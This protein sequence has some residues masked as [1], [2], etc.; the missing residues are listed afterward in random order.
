MFYTNV[1]ATINHNGVRGL[2]S[3][4]Q[5]FISIHQYCGLTTNCIHTTKWQSGL[6]QTHTHYRSNQM[7]FISIF[8][9]S[10]FVF[11]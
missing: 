5:I 8:A 11:K 7:W 6:T 2:S 3:H 10:I 4:S 9:F 1:F